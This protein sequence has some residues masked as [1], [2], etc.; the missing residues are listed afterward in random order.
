MLLVGSFLN[1]SIEIM[2]RHPEQNQSGPALYGALRFLG[3]SLGGSS[4]PPLREPRRSSMP[5]EKEL[6]ELPRRK[7]RALQMG[8]P[9]K[10]DR[11]PYL[12][13]T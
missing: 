4:S 10:V 1:R 2:P 12:F 7:E 3:K 13:T 11:R 6:E 8:G 9:E 5:F